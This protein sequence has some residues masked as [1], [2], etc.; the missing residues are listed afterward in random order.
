MP[1][2][3]ATPR[4]VD[5]K[6]NKDDFL[7]AWLGELGRTTKYIQS[8]TGLTA[9]QV[10]YRLN[11]ANVRRMD[12]RNGITATSQAIEELAKPMQRQLRSRLEQHG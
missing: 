6:V 10:T 4:R 1:R 5:F 11:K 2:I 3:T 12:Y 9:C 8:R 7:A